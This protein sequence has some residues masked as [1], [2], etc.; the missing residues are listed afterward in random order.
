MYGTLCSVV[1]FQFQDLSECLCD[2]LRNP[3]HAPNRESC[4]EL[5]RIFC[6]DKQ[7][8]DGFLSDPLVE[9]VIEFAGLSHCNA[10]QNITRATRPSGTFF[11][12]LL[13]F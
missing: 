10:A 3:D 4:L 11:G 2:V 1:L 7:G 12:F 6:R 8:I 9:I 5:I 13:L